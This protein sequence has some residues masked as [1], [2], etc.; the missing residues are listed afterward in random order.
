MTNTILDLVIYGLLGLLLTGVG[1]G[2]I[3]CDNI[4]KRPRPR[5]QVKIIDIKE[6]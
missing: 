1:I 4:S 2:I 6:V 5:Y 3:I